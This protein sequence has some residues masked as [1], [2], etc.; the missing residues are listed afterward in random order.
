MPA[1]R[2]RHRHDTS[3]TP[4]RIRTGVIVSV[5][6]GVL[7]MVVVGYVFVKRR[8]N[9]RVKVGCID[10]RDGWRKEGGGDGDLEVGIVKDAAPVYAK[11]LREG[12]RRVA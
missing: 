2:S 12:E 11:E 3:M 6:V 9:G 7:A 5:V 1:T 8:Q 10:G 4:E